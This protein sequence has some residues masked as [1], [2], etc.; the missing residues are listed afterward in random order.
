M[1]KPRQR[2]CGAWKALAA[3]AVLAAALCAG[4]AMFENRVLRS[5]VDRLEGRLEA[6][7]RRGAQELQEAPER[8]AQ[9]SPPRAAPA[10][11]GPESGL[12]SGLESVLE[13]GAAWPERNVSAPEGAPH[14]VRR[15]LRRRTT[16]AC[17]CPPG[18]SR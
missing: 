14:R 8:G 15:A 7:E 10:E 11:S 16:G 12:G 18:E 4:Y 17:V 6:L 13:S 2:V 1:E 3:F 9:E 5:R